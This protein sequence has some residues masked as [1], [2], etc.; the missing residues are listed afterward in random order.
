MKKLYSIISVFALLVFITGCDKLL[1]LEPA[2]SISENVALDSDENV[3]NVL[4]GAY[5]LFDEPGIYGGNLLRN[6]ELLAGDGEIQWVGTYIDPRQVFNK[7]MLTTNS[8]V[9][10]HWRDAYAV[11][12][13]SNNILSA[14]NVVNEDDQDWVAGEALF[15]R[16]LMYFDLVRFFGEQ[17]QPGTQN[18]QL[19]VPIVLIPT[20]SITDD[21]FV[22]RATVEEVYTQVI[23]DLTEAASKLPLDNDVYASR[24]AANA[25]LA[26][27]YLQKGDFASARDAANTVI[28][29]GQYSL[30]PDYADVFNQD[31]N[32]SEDIFATQI[33]PQ[34]RF[35]SMTEFFSIREYGGRDGDIEIL[36]G[37]LNLYPAGDA[38]RDL[39]FL[40]NGAIRTGKWNNQYG[41]INLIRL[42][43]M[44][45][46]R[47]E[48]NIRLGT[49]L[50]ATPLS[51][52]N[53]ILT[54]A[55]LTPAGSV[56]L[57]NILMERRLELAFE[58]H[59]I[60]DQ[61]R[62]KE[63]VGAR[64]WND[65]ELLFPIP[66]RELEANPGLKTQQNPGY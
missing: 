4:L 53:T 20:N 64:P 57:N 30:L 43:E 47:A 6:C 63:N 61:R 22:S 8:E 1:D 32:T 31:D 49:T 62:L 24:G 11:I 19:G 26:R 52:Y 58:G 17:Y 34:N 29:S 50:G 16:G 46:I 36:N 41:V 27:V 51:D 3:K 14:I 39:F 15:L 40:G 13:T 44:Y 65:P 59:R 60:H 23:A 66:A 48:G 5:A 35:S 56:T 18:T 45:L 28:A 38:R 7:D 21:S 33:T 37:H 25:L 54:R 12:N 10:V 2:Q 42:A 55:N 9:Y